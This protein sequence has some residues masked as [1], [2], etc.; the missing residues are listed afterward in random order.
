MIVTLKED[1]FTVDLLSKTRAN[2][3]D[4][5]ANPYDTAYYLYEDTPANVELWFPAK[6]SITFYKKTTC[7]RISSTI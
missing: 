1:G 7:E 2:K 5:L 6:A 3:F 4:R